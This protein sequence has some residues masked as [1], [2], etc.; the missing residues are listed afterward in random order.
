MVKMESQIM[1]SIVFILLKCQLEEMY[2][3]VK[4][5]KAN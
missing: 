3:A 5:S 1:N 2:M 4:V